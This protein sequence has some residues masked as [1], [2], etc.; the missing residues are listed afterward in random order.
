VREY[1]LAHPADCVLTIYR[2]GGTAYGRPRIVE[3][4]GETP[5]GVLAGVTIRW[6]P[7]EARLLTP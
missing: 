3:L 6:E 1:W 4:S 7:G 5:V 2:L